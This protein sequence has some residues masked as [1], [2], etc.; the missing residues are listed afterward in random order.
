MKDINYMQLGATLFIPASHKDLQVILSG[1]KYP[2]L[3][4]LV[5][6]FEDG[7]EEN[8]FDYAM[9][10]VENILSS[11]SGVSPLTF[12]RAKDVTHLEVLLKLKSIT[13]IT[14]FVLAKFSLLNAESYLDLVQETKHLIMPSIEADELFNHQKLHKLKEIILTN[15]QKVL[16]VRFGLEDMLRQLSM[17]RKCD[18]S[19]FD[20]SVTASVTGNFIATFKSVG[21]SVSGG[22]Y[23]CFK[24][25]KGFVKDVKRDIKEGLISKTIIHPNQIALFDEA[26]KV[27]KE[28]Y[29]EALQIV[30]AER[31]VF[32]LEGKMAESLTM[33]PY[34][35]E[36]IH[37]AQIYGIKT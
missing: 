22:V 28:E 21:F 2:N 11:I 23:P 33:S 14:G 27:Q 19:L 1:K 7:L 24:D 13:T 3:K 20:L 10:R 34:S 12:I 29:E 31:K 5:I 9:Q 4:S 32:K 6:D 35:E 16:L 17:R 30:N 26:Y 36:L 15:K 37:R 8:D 25:A 18:E